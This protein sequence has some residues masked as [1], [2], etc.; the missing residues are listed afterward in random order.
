MWWNFVAR[1]HDEIVAA[2]ADWETERSRGWLARFGQVAGYPGEALPA[3]ALPN[4][5]LRPRK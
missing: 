3:P 4:L 5:R 2:R 1:D